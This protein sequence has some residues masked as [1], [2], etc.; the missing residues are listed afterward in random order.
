[1]NHTIGPW[2]VAVSSKWP[3]NK[4][5]SLALGVESQTGSVE[6]LTVADCLSDR[7][8]LLVA[9]A[10]DLLE[11]LHMIVNQCLNPV[12]DDEESWRI[13]IETAEDA[14]KKAEGE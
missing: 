1:M 11:A 7:D 4:V 12:F 10:P 3:H 9:A 2:G 14:I 8:A 6:Y 5:V 13:V